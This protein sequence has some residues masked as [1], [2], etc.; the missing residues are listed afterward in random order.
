MYRL[1]KLK[2]YMNLENSKERQMLQMKATGIV[3]NIDIL[4][5]IV[6]M[7]YSCGMQQEVE[8]A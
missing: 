1:Y 8:T 4:G 5:R 7:F 6:L 2:F 3:R